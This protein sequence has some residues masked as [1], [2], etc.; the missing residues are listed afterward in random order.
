MLN[1]FFAAA[2]KTLLTFGKNKLKSTPGFIAILHTWDQKL[3]AHF[4]LHCLVAGLDGIIRFTGKGN[5]FA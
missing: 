3:K 4:H 1:I 5:G 2:S